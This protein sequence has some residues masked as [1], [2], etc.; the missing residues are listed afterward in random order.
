MATTP[1]NETV[2][3][4]TGASS[5]IGAATAQELAR[6]GARVILAA[7]RADELQAQADAITTA[8]GVASILTVDMAD[9]ASVARLAEQAPQ[10]YGR[11][12]A[13]VNNAGVGS[14]PPFARST[15]DAIEHIVGVNLLGVMLLTHA[16]L[17]AMLARKRGAIICVA[18]VAGQ[19]AVDPLYSAT[20]FGVRGF[21]LALRRQ[22]RGSGVSVSVISPGYIRTPRNRTMRQRLPGPEI[23][24]NAIARLIVHP[25]REVVAPG[26]YRAA[27]GIEGLAPWLV[28]RGIPVRP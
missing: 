8:G 26:Y 19:I 25:R 20:K 13:L 3:L 2:A 4:V 28:D 11:V 7:R 5:G 18:S 16:L 21:A 10:V 9:P 23:G 15:P 14:G 6:R 12:D 22:L 17:P 1:L 27:T 24:A